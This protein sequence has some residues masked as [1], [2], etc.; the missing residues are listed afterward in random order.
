MPSVTVPAKLIAERLSAPVRPT[1]PEMYAD[2]RMRAP[3]APELARNE[4]LELQRRAMWKACR[5]VVRGMLWDLVLNGYEHE[6][7]LAAEIG[8]AAFAAFAAGFRN[9]AKFSLVSGEA[10]AILVPPGTPNG[11]WRPVVRRKSEVYVEWDDR[12]SDLAPRLVAVAR[13][14]RYYGWMDGQSFAVSGDGQHVEM[15]QTS[16]ALFA[17][18]MPAICLQTGEMQLEEDGSTMRPSGVVEPLI[19]ANDKLNQANFDLLLVSSYGAV[20]LRAIAGVDMPED[21]AEAREQKIK[22][23]VDRIMTSS[24]PDAKFFSLVGTPMEPYIHLVSAALGDLAVQAAV[25]PNRL[26][27]DFENI[28]ADTVA[29]IREGYLAQIRAIRDAWEPSIEGFLRAVAIGQILSDPGPDGRISWKPIELT[30]LAAVMDAGQKAHAMGM[31]AEALVRR[32][33]AWRGEDLD[34]LVDGYQESRAGETASSLV[35]RI[36]SDASRR[37][38]GAG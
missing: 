31:N 22:L 18:T 20:T 6:N 9:L 19:E 12:A 8:N 5:M 4:Q 33:L 34:S 37:S 21:D 16:A 36:V 35:S 17:G 25:P 14:G 10:Y 15:G 32:E 27:P 7:D 2:G 24:N 11:V 23:A 1:I 28:G 29:N 3:F 38:A 26:L 13:H 30:S